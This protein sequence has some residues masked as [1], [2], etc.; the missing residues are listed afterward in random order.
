MKICNYLKKALLLVAFV[1]VI[2]SAQEQRVV[3]RIVQDQSYFLNEFQT[4]IRL[5]KRPFK[6]QILLQH[7][8]GIYV[9]ASIKDSVYRFTETSPIADFPY[10]KLLQLR[11][12][13]RWNTNKELNISEDGWSYWFYSDS[14]SWHSYNP[15]IYPIGSK[16]IICTKYI[17]QLYASADGSVIKIKNV[18]TPLYLFFIAVKEYDESGKPKSELL[19]R[20]VKIEWG[21][22]E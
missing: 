17:K 8:D 9:F 15:K 11:E 22:D 14:A 3:I 2:S 19:R 6:F 7:M 13:D 5:K 1:P 10:L 12:D 4:N 16:E 21:D 20:K 18:E